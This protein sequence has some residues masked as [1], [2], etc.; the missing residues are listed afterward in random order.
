MSSQWPCCQEANATQTASGT[1]R[2]IAS[3]KQARRA[4]LAETANHRVRSINVKGRNVKYA[5]NPVLL[6]FGD[7]VPNEKT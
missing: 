2:M 4:Q 1:D 6:R 7:L 3:A 5:E